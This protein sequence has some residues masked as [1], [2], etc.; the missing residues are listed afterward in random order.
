MLGALRRPPLL[1]RAARIG[2]QDY[3]RERDLRRLLKCQA[4]PGH[5]Q[6]VMKLMEEEG[7]LNESRTNGDG[8]YNV[9]RHVEVMIAMLGEALLIRSDKPDLRPVN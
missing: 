8:N 1:I 9:T 5:R 2:A 3:K 4:L 6:S 7:I